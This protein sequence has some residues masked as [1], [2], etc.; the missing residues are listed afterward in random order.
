[1]ARQIDYQRYLLERETRRYERRK[2][3]EQRYLE[4]KNTNTNTSLSARRTSTTAPNVVMTLQNEEEAQIAEAIQ[5]SK[6]QYKLEQRQQRAINSNSLSP[7]FFGANLNLKN[8]EI[9]RKEKR[10]Q[11]RENQQQQEVLSNV[12][13]QQQNFEIQ[14]MNNN[15]YPRILKQSDFLANAP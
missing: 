4:L 1:M 3:R 7:V 6:R 15:I 5:A 14:K 10:K 8:E 13:K 9:K 2:K 11:R 12:I